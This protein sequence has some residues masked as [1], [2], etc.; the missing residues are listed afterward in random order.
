MKMISV[1]VPMY[2]AEEYIDAC[3]ESILAQTYKNFE[4][5]I[6]DDGSIDRSSLMIDSYTYNDERVRIVHREN[7]G[8]A[9]ARNI[10]VKYAKGD[11]VCFIDADD[12]VDSTYLSYLA[13]LIA[14]Y[15]A[16]IAICGYRNVFNED[17]LE[18]EAVEKVRK[19]MT[20]I[21]A[22]EDLL[23]QRHFMSVPWGSLSKK[24][25][26]D[27]VAFPEGTKA[28]DMGT[29]YK[30]YGQASKVAFGDKPLYNYFQR[31]DN[32]MFSTSS[33]RNIDYFKHSRKMV[34]HLAH[35]YRESLG[36]GYSRHF[37]TCFQILSETGVTT[38]N[39]VLTTAVYD[40]IRK[41][42]Y[43]VLHDSKAKLRNR[44]A[45]G[46]SMVSI[47]AMHIMLRAGYMYK[48]SKLRK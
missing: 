15:N 18:N 22:M 33:V 32:T 21:E 8:A 3:V 14:E 24:K 38:G 16:D 34:N 12:T 30:L 6:I 40:D 7:E 27:K 37:S 45:A 2:N 29:I 23:Y 17:C 39:K 11:F 46:L 5:I 4:L 26:W 28:E 10:G 48:K 42:Q 25:L 36:A 41:L 31:S 47:R 20:G 44:L 35:N 1:I 43:R 13:E 19:S 9:V